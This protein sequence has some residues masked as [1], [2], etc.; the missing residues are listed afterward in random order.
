[1]SKVILSL[2]GR[3]GAGKTSAAKH[4]QEKYG[5][6]P[7]NF[8]MVIRDYAAQNGIELKQRSDYANT[9]VEMIKKHGWDYTLNIALGLTDDYVCIDD[10]RSIKYVEAFAAAGGK[11]IAFDC[12][13]AVRFAHVQAHPDKVKYPPTLEAFKQSEAEDEATLIA[14][15]LKFETDAVAQTADYHIDASGSLARTLEQLDQIVDA[16]LAKTA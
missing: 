4:L 2:I 7:F 13:V 11:T 15:E 1:M 10:L 12:P 6:T 14:P 3:P 16:I 9:H 8:G 5:F